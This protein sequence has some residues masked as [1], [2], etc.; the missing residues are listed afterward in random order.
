MKVQIS[1]V[2]GA[3]VAMS[4]CA[5]VEPHPYKRPVTQATVE[6][7]RETDVIVAEN[8]TGVAKSWYYTSTQGA[9]SSYGL[10]GALVAVAMDAIINAAPSARAQR[11]ANETAETVTPQWITASLKQSFEDAR[12]GQASVAS[13]SATQSAALTTTE[14]ASLVTAAL[15]AQDAVTAQPAAALTPP[16]PPQ[17]VYFGQVNAQQKILAPSAVQDTV[18][19]STSYLLSEDASTLRVTAFASYENAALAYQTPYTFKKVP[20]DELTG[21]AYR[22]TFVYESERFPIPTL[23]PELKER[24]ISLASDSYKDASGAPPAAGSEDAKKLA[25][26][27]EDA[28][29][30]TLTKSE[31]SIFLIREWTK[32]GGEPMK[33]EI[34][35]AHDFIA[36]YVLA[37][38]NAT[39]VPNMAGQDQLVETQPDGRTVRIIGAGA[40][41][42]SYTSSPGN[43]AD[44]TTYGN[45]AS[46]AK[47]NNE[48]IR[49]LQSQAKQAKKAGE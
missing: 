3:C 1:F 28:R 17:G 18:E 14:G 20:K 47:V 23:S 39:A 42:G 11:A 13:L 40:G 45:T 31:A 7:M 35:K 29:D 48:A 21:P 36:K 12:P 10:L 26:E 33:R 34:D 15:P 44:F 49:A 37:D 16:A 41:A 46:I 4:A 24:L 27:L 43:V 5:T 9:A 19:V 2:M 38:L 25:K 32:N 22:N 30:D 6:T 8:N